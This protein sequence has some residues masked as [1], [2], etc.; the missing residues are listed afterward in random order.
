MRHIV[1]HPL[2]LPGLLLT[3]RLLP[4]LGGGTCS[5]IDLPD[6]GEDAEGVGAHKVVVD[7]LE[8]GR[9]AALRPTRGPAADLPPGGHLGHHAAQLTSQRTSKG[10]PLLG[11]P[12]S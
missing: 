1:R 2:T 9:H 11:R 6:P 5:A 10:W 3:A 12:P 4:P 8:K 7:L